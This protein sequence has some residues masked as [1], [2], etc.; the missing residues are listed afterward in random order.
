VNDKT[1]MN[2]VNRRPHGEMDGVVAAL[3]ICLFVGDAVI[4]TTGSSEP[5]TGQPK[6]FGSDGYP[7]QA[8]FGAAI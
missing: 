2:R 1:A 3:E 8:R 4:F 5:E 6:P 7:L